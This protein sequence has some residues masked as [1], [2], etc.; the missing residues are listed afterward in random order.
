MPEMRVVF[1]ARQTM[2]LRLRTKISPNLADPMA[3][4]VVDA[5]QCPETIYCTA[6]RNKWPVSDLMAFLELCS[7]DL[8]VVHL[9]MAKHRTS[10]I[11]LISPALIE[12]VG[13]QQQFFVDSAS[14]FWITQ[15]ICHMLSQLRF[16]QSSRLINLLTSTWSRFCT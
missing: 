4:V 6:T 12:M 7:L 2:A 11:K 3:E 13:L 15:P 5:V 10:R 1:W 8:V 14:I 16:A 9:G